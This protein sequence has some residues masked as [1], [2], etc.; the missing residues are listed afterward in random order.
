MMIAGVSRVGEAMYA[1]VCWNGSASMR[2]LP[3]RQQPTPYR[4]WVSEIMLQQTQVATVLDYYRRFLKSFPTVE[5]LAEADPQDLLTH[6]EGLGYYRRARSLHAAAKQIV[7]Q[8]G[9]EFP[10]TFEEVVALPGIGRY[11]AG[12]ILSISKDMRLPI[13]EGN[14]QRVFSR[15]I[16]LRGPATDR[17][18][19]NLL[20]QFAEEMLPREHVGAFNQAS[21]ELGALVCSPLAPDCGRCPV[22]RYCSAHKAGLQESIPGKVSRIKYEDRTEYAMVVSQG[23]APRR[24]ARYLLRMIPEGG[25]WAG[26]WDFPRTNGV[27][28]LSAAVAASGL[29][30]QMGTA[31]LAGKRLA[32]IRHAV[33]RF[34]IKLH[35]HVA[36][37]ADPDKIPPR[38]WRFASLKQM[39]KLPMSVTGRH[40]VKLLRD[41]SKSL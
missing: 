13:L 32:T 36:D 29:S 16:A 33:T 7:S 10:A 2:D 20:W 6:W 35:V 30:D 18:A 34:R 25:R 8:H 3:W 21:M 4:V 26:L 40:I 1:D 28:Y 17:A 23:G 11:T 15:W 31:I 41:E 9:G 38:P 5:A 12:A 14:T 24:T 37:L 19:T 27:E 22:S 39:E